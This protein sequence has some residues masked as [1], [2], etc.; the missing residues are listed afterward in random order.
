MSTKHPQKSVT[1]GP[2][3]TLTGGKD[4]TIVSNTVGP[5]WAAPEHLIGEVTKHNAPLVAGAPL[6]LAALREVYRLTAFCFNPTSRDVKISGIAEQV[7]KALAE[8]PTIEPDTTDQSLA[9]LLKS[10]GGKP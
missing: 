4:R 10:Y 3:F 8:E 9:A 1:P 2:W 6:M 7:L 5:Q